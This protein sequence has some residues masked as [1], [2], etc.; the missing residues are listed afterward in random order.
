[1]EGAL[2]LAKMK[3]LYNIACKKYCIKY[4]KKLP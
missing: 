2:S 4:C 3:I 1:M